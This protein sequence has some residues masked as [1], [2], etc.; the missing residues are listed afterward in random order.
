MSS[1]EYYTIAIVCFV[2]GA[3][4]LNDSFIGVLTLLAGWYFLAKSSEESSKEST[5][6]H[7]PS[8]S[9]R[10]YD[11]DDDDDEKGFVKE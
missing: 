1:S 2:I 3:I 7:D 6:W 8:S 11:D 4:K 10:T 9:Y 5:E